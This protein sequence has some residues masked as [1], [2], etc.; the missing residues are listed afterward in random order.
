MSVDADFYVFAPSNTDFEGN[1]TSK[2]TIPFQLPINLNT[3]Y[4]VALTELVIPNSFN[5]FQSL[6]NRSFFFSVRNVTNNTYKLKTVLSIPEV[7]YENVTHVI[8]NINNII[9]QQMLALQNEINV[10]ENEFLKVEY[11]PLFKKVKINAPVSNSNYEQ[12]IRF[13]PY[14][15]QVFGLNDTISYPVGDY[16]YSDNIVFLKN[17]SPLL[18]VTLDI[19]EPEY[20]GNRKLRSL[21]Q[22]LITDTQN[23]VIQ[24]TFDHPHYKR[25]VPASIPSVHFQILDDDF[26]ILK[27]SS[28]GSTFAVLHFSPLTRKN[29]ICHSNTNRKR[30]AESFVFQANYV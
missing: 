15:S 14:L 20:V 10:T 22:V 23:D 16:T 9:S 11:I 17:D 7:F 24:L 8:Q 6:K 13:L 3:E 26:D 5:K 29:D 27:A 28:K 21:R 2:F 25:V 4:Q 1:T 18:Y 19:I 12:K 30:R